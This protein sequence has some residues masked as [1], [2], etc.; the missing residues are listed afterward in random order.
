M[1]K[2]L[3][4]LFA[5]LILSS[6]PS[7][8][9]GKSEASGIP[10]RAAAKETPEPLAPPSVF[11]EAVEASEESPE[12]DEKDSGAIDSASILASDATAIDFLEG[13]WTNG[14]TD[15][16][17][18]ERGEGILIQ[19]QTN[20]PYPACNRYILENGVLK[21]KLLNEQGSVDDYEILRMEILDENTL[22]VYSFYTGEETDFIRDSLS[23][24]PSNISDTYVFWSMD[25]AAVFLEGEW[26]T[27]ALDYFVVTNSAE[28]GT[29]L[30]TD[31]PCPTGT[32]MGFCDLKLCAYTMDS[33]GKKT[34]EPAYGF[35]IYGKDTMTVHCFANET[36]YEF[37]RISG[38]IDRENL[39]P[40]YV[41]FCDAR[42]HAFLKGQWK[43]K[44][45]ENTFTLIE[46]NDNIGWRTSLPLEK[47]EDYMFAQTGL[48]GL[49]ED[50]EGG[51]TVT[52]LYEFDILSGDEITVHV[53][54]D[55]SIHTL[56]RVPE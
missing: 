52:K 20:L 54:S 29:Q 21:G 23:V 19:W 55:D 25:R 49:D 30:N 35:H 28:T 45:G 46:T 56:T 15:F 8:Y 12:N 2:T 16:L 38:E 41:F 37:V 26:M 43:E 9:A 1:K 31:L 17:Y 14:R 7:A 53:L 11:L 36:D 6:F 50:T 4:L 27:S 47:H 3:S 32:G 44:D 42:A 34:F 51:L 18:A 22:R 5:F 48:L 33:N 10:N 40:A 39:D 13:Y 24:D